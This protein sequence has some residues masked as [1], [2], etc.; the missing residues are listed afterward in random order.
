MMFATARGDVRIGYDVLGTGRP[1]VMLHDFGESSRFWCEHGCV[2]T[3]LTEGRQIVLIDLRSHGD[4][5]QPFDATAC[6]PINC[7]WDVIAVLDHAAIGRADMLGYGFGGRIALC[8]AAWAS[9][10]VHAVAAGG[11]HPYAERTHLS[12][13]GSVRGLEPCGR[14]TTEDA[15]TAPEHQLT[16]HVLAP[17]STAL[18]SD[19]P[20]ISDAVAR[21]GV[22]IL[23]FVG[24]KDPHFS[25]CLSFAEQS[26]AQAIA[27][28]NHDYTTTAT[29]GTAEFLPQVLRFFESPSEFT[30]SERLPPSR[31]SG[32]WP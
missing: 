23:L 25:L 12:S 20:D 19:W 8:I 11:A 31:W 22:P 27:L 17:L 16:S 30:T 4:S 28:E 1:I 5:S 24:E 2:K 6:D 32:S 14:P 18:A 9:N 7:S 10:R 29:A 13:D 3:C 26:G 15:H 21:S